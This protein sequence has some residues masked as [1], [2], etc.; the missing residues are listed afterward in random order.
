MKTTKKISF[1]ILLIVG[2]MIFFRGNVI[3]HSVEL[4]PNSLIR[5]PI[6]IYNGKGS[7]SISSSE[8][9]YSL[10]YQAVEIPNETYSKIEKTESDGKKQLDKI[11]EESDSLK[12]ELDNLKTIYDE[13]YQKYKDKLESGEQDEELDTLKKE[14]ET[15]KNNYQNKANEY[16]NKIDEYNEKVKKVNSEINDLIPSYIENNWIKTEDGSFSVDLSKF[17]GDK[18]FAIWVKLVS[19]DG[20]ISYDEGT[21][22]MSGTKVDDVVVEGISLDKTN[23]NLKKGSS[24]TLNATITPSNA[25]NKLIT[26][27]SDNENIVT[28]LDGKVTAKE[29]GTA[30][31]TATTQDGNYSATC[32]ITVL[33]DTNNKEDSGKDDTNNKED[34]DKDDTTAPGKLPQTGATG[35]IALSV[36]AVVGISIIVYKSYAKYKDIK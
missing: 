16:N 26:W 35:T 1:I 11:K 17:S 28:V 6:S 23:L 4:D 27:T 13:A 30:T 33:D 31:I 2:V 12:K 32:K 15:A 24:Y 10:Y 20:T 14:Y 5:L 22:T 29:V 3:A 21:Y 36:L 19:S 8:S 7:I 9:N 25:T 34:S 18:A